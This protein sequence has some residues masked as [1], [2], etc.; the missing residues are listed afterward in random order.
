MSGKYLLYGCSMWVGQIFDKL[1]IDYEK[2]DFSD[3][4][5][6]LW[7]C[8]FRGAKGI[9]PPGEIE[10][11]EYT[12]CIVGS[13]KYFDEI[14]NILLELGFSKKQIIPVDFI[15]AMWE[16]WKKEDVDRKW[17]I[18][19]EDEHIQIVKK[20]YLD[21]DKLSCIIHAKGL[22]WNNLML[23]FVDIFKSKRD[24]LVENLVDGRII[25]SCDTSLV[26]PIAVEDDSVLYK[27]SVGDVCKGI[28]WLRIEYSKGAF[29]EDIAQLKLYEQ[30]VNILSNQLS[31]PYYDEDYLLLSKM[32]NFGGTILDVGANYGQSMYAF[33]HLT[34]ESRIISIEVQPDLYEVLL[35]LK[36]LI[37]GDDRVSIINSGVSNKEEELVWHE[38]ENPE[39]SGSFDQ[40][41]I[42]SRKLNVKINERI[43][44]CKTLDKLIEQKDDIWFIK[45]DVE[46]LEYEALQGAEEIIGKNYPL[47]LIEQNAKLEMIQALLNDTYDVYYYDFTNDKFS[48]KRVS[49]LNC[50]LIPKVAYRSA[51]INQIVTTRLES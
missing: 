51:R 16:R 28:P 4:N 47:I 15:V 17:R 40:E 31:F 26:D 8:K 37:D 32:N 18:W 48:R 20:W 35:K 1:E 45:L 44:K 22:L 21:G 7:G 14:E 39:M 49:R 34:K 42:K 46:G 30:F 38:P 6:E 13:Q 5:S 25:C 41:F 10:C 9:I 2:L 19:Y 50:W 36:E 24:V 43:A 3:T 12:C 29:S 11:A 23:E 27:I 33:L